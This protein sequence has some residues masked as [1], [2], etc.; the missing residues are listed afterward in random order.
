M[1]RDMTQV[2][3]FKLALDAAGGN[4]AAAAR[5]LRC[6]PIDV[7][8]MLGIPE[9]RGRKTPVDPSPR[10]AREAMEAAADDGGAKVRALGIRAVARALKVPWT[11]V[12]DR[13][14]PK[15]EVDNRAD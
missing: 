2:A 3:R 10:E 7:R 8:A 1:M 6:Q 15:N 11:T 4:V 13:I 12:R 5:A 14:R 9:K